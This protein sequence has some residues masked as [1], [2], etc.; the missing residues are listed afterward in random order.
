MSEKLNWSRDH[1]FFKWDKILLGVRVMRPV[2]RAQRERS[3]SDAGLATMFIRSPLFRACIHNH[4]TRYL[5]SSRGC[6]A[7]VGRAR[8][9]LWLE[10]RVQEKGDHKMDTVKVRVSDTDN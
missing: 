1:P 6:Y 4:L 3:H 5:R 10:Q 8:E 9:G 2:R 7:S